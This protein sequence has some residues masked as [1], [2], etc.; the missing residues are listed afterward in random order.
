[1]NPMKSYLDSGKSGATD[2]S[3]SG[4]S[5]DTVMPADAAPLVEDEDSGMKTGELTFNKPAGFK[6]P[7]GV[8]DG[9][10][11]DAMATLK[12]MN[13]KLVLAEVDGSPVQDESSDEDQDKGVGADSENDMSDSDSDSD[14]SAAPDDFL[15][16]VEKHA[17]KLPA[18]QNRK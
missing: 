8:K 15:G 9:E 10:T 17:S 11:F 12:L 1:M 5:S 2:E 3:P 4:N 6:I 13:G 18:I 14:K 7:D 16:S